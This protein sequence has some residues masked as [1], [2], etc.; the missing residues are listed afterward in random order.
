MFY[1]T[2]KT[3]LIGV[4]TMHHDTQ[5]HIVRDARP[6][7]STMEPLKQE[8]SELLLIQKL[9]SERKLRQHAQF[10]EPSGQRLQR[11]G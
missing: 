1:I 8:K 2:W 5:L 3:F 6:Y 11:F 9:Y 4:K 10:H 7:A